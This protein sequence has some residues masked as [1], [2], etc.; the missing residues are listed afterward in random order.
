MSFVEDFSIIKQLDPKAVIQQGKDG[1]W[2][3]KAKIKVKADGK[4]IVPHKTNAPTA[5][6]CAR[7][8]MLELTGRYSRNV[9]GVINCYNQEVF[10]D[11]EREC[12]VPWWE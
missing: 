3:L 4:K 10:W 6:D 12:F 9:L 2:N 8:M 5:E 7:C 11:S 1:E